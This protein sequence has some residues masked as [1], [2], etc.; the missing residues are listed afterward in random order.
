MLGD[1]PSEK[2]SVDGWGGAILSNPLHSDPR[3]L[4]GWLEAEA[5]LPVSL[6]TPTSRVPS[7]IVGGELLRGSAGRAVSGL[8]APRAA[9]RPPRD[10]AESGIKR[11][12]RTCACW[13]RGAGGPEPDVGLCVF[14][15][16]HEA[17]VEDVVG[18]GFT[19]CQALEDVDWILGCFYSNSVSR[20]CVCEN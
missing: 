19:T 17:L 9:R 13:V 20:V 7:S 16:D 14:L 6:R 12:T 3:P 10:Q 8:R 2:K 11:Q 5:A 18:P 4:T 1:G 15:S